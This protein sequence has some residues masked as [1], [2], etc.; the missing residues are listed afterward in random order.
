MRK[1]NIL[2]LL[3]KLCKII[4]NSNPILSNEITA[5]THRKFFTLT[6][7]GLKVIAAN[8]GKNVEYL[9]VIAIPTSIGNNYECL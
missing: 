2:H 3:P 9:L 5:G 4:S 6:L 1:Y 8:Q 7:N